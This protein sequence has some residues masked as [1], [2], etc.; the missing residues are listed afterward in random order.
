MKRILISLVVLGLVCA[1]AGLAAAG[2]AICEGVESEN[3]AA[4]TGHQLTRGVANAGL[5]W[6]EMVR[7]P[8]QELNNDGNILVGLA[9]GVGHTFI[10]LA[11]G[12]GEVIT[13]PFP[14]ANDGSRIA[15]N[16]PSCM[17]QESA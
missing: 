16:C 4:K 3:H 17:W 7:Q 6:M 8:K 10:R 11:K 2:C 14:H 1:P 5:S 13:A 15:S 12:L 9:E